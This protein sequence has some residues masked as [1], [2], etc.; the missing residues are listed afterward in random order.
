MEFKV[1][2]LY[3]GT[4][5]YSG[6]HADCMRWINRKY[7]SRKQWFGGSKYDKG[8]YMPEPLQ[9]VGI[10]K[11]K[12]VKM[13]KWTPAE[14]KWLTANIDQKVPWLVGHLSRHTYQGV[15]VKRSL[16]RRKLREE[17]R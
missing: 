4:E 16:I 15:A 12:P 11:R 3:D 17:P 5:Y 10:K 14:L 6:T 7:H 1:L 2:G 13:V 9:I 8:N